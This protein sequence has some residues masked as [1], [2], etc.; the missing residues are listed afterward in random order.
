M[1]DL[2]IKA[3]GTATERQLGELLEPY[4]DKAMYCVAY[5]SGRF[6]AARGDSL[7]HVLRDASELLELRVF[8]STHELWAHRSTLGTPFSWRVADD[9]TLRQN[10]AEQP[11]AFL[12]AAAHHYLDGRQFLDISEAGAVNA[13]GSRELRTTVGGRYALPIE[14]GQNAAL[15]RSYLR[16]DAQTGAAA[17]VDWRM[18]GFERFKDAEG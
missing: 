18:V 10:A 13:Y 1:M 15:T 7:P 2:W 14:E 5:F 4:T 11:D 16:Y 12:R 8:D 6:F 9:E 3:A 17:A